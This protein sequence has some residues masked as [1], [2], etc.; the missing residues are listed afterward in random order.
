MNILENNRYLNKPEYFKNGESVKKIVRLS[1][2]PVLG[3][4]AFPSIIIVFIIEILRPKDV[5]ESF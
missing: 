3:E 5:S 2:I 4:G 1:Y